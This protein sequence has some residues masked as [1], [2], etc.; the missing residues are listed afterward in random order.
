MPRACPW[1]APVEG[2]RGRVSKPFPLRHLEHG[3]CWIG[4]RSHREGEEVAGMAGHLRQLSPG[5]GS[6]KP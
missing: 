6:L 1:G 4:G 5:Q 3:Q 2:L